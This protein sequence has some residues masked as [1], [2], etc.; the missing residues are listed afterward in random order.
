ML[1]GK[2]SFCDSV[3][4]LPLPPSG[5]PRAAFLNRRDAYR[6]RD[7]WDLFTRTWNI[8]E[9]SK[10]SNFTL[11]KTQIVEFSQVNKIL[12]WNSSKNYIY[13]VFLSR[14]AYIVGTK[15]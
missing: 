2:I 11:N 13:F 10:F 14:E 6:N 5:S 12:N 8:F 1:I 4:T 9:N 15:T 7:F 3:L